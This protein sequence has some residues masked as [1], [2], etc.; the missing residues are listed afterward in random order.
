MPL[1]RLGLF[2]SAEVLLQ[3]WCLHCHL[4]HPKTVTFCNICT[5]TRSMFT[6]QRVIYT[7]KGDDSKC[8][9]L[10]IM[11]L[12]RQTLF[13]LSSTPQPIVC[14]CMQCSC[15][16]LSSTPQS[17]VGTHMRCSCL[18]NTSLFAHQPLSGW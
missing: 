2:S 1:F 15:Y 3:P 9:F 16:P 12:F 14:T 6:I 13:L 18:S 7:I 8:I 11:P 10:R 5:E 4:R 17:S